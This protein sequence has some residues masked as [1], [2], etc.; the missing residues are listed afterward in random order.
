MVFNLLGYAPL[1]KS[2]AFSI[3]RMQ[4]YLCPKFCCGANLCRADRSHLEHHSIWNSLWHDRDNFRVWGVWSLGGQNHPKMH[5]LAYFGGGRTRNVQWSGHGG[6]I[7]LKLCQKKFLAQN[8]T[9][10]IYSL[11]LQNICYTYF[12]FKRTDSFYKELF[13]H[14]TRRWLVE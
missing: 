7:S 11:I 13:S 8:Y 4:P 12:I 2:N 10:N 3:R 9:L 6:G 1:L 14:A 5:E